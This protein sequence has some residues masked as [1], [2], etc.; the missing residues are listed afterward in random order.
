[1]SSAQVAAFA[2][3]FARIA[4]LRFT[5]NKK[6]GM[7]DKKIIL[8]TGNEAIAEAAIRAGCGFYAGYP[9][10]PQ[11]E[12]TAYMAKNMPENNR[13]FIQA[14]SEL[15]AINMVLGASAAGVRAMTSSSSP[16]IS[17][18]QEGISYLAGCE[19]PAVIV[20]IMRG[21]PGLGN[22]SPSQSDYFQA[23]KGGGHGDYRSIVLAPS[24]VQEAYRLMF[25]AFDLADKYRNPVVILGDG[26]LGQMMEPL[27][28]ETGKIKE[29]PKPWALTGCSGRAPN[30]IR[31]LLLKDG[32]LEAL[33]LK[34]QKKYA[35]A[36]VKEQRWEEQFKD[37]A[38]IIIVA[39]GG[40]ARIAKGVVR[41]LRQKDKKVGLIRPISLW[42]FPVKAFARSGGR[43]KVK[44][45]V[46]EMSY[47][48]MVEDVRL[49][50][51]CA[52]PV[53]FLGRAGGGIL[54]EDEIINRINRLMLKA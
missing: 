11:N 51:N 32:A 54:T 18:K 45:L 34:L 16:G 49:A 3:L 19:L 9:I 29:Y 21:G 14:E 39:Y 13:V 37:D 22:I 44:Y 15:A 33:N 8:M 43:A 7:A 53:E 4:V 1:M 6:I 17:L 5:N 50:V 10:T 12:L 26:M 30:I 46:L 28:L 23:T 20:N 2:R 48:Q 52:A 41:Q 27:S 42:P 47:G 25:D 40:M 38:K 35:A 24:S 36:Q 31:S